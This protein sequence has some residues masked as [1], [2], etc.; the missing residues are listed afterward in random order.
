[1][2]IDISKHP[3]RMLFRVGYIEAISAQMWL[4]PH[5]WAAT[6]ARKEEVLA[7]A[8]WLLEVK[9]LPGDVLYLEALDV[10]FSSAEG[11]EAE[12]QNKLQALLFPRSVESPA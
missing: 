3:G 9:Q 11:H 5:F 8:E 10:P 7:A 4:G 1:M 6:G 12:L 2:T